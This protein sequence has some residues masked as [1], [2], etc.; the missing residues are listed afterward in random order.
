MRRTS[1]CQIVGLS[2]KQIFN[3]TRRGNSLAV[4]QAVLR[5]KHVKIPRQDQA[6]DREDQTEM[7]K[8]EAKDVDGVVAEG[9]EFRVRQTVYDEE[10]WGGDV[11]DEGTPENGN[12]PVLA[13]GDDDVQVAAELIA[14]VV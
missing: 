8:Y 3:N 5:H 10:D 6:D 12:A 4:I 11:T 7:R 2:L 9:P 13:A 1:L 14:L